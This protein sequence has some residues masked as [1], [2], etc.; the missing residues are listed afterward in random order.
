MIINYATYSL[1]KYITSIK[2]KKLEEYHHAIKYV[3]KVNK[4]NS[5]L[6]SS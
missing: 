1:Y 2:P 4:E 5:L 6:V 3:A